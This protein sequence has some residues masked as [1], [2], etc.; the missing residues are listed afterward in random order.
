MK[1]HGKLRKTKSRL[2]K[3]SILSGALFFLSF[4]LIGQDTIQE[5]NRSHRV[6]D[7][8]L[9]TKKGKVL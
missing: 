2:Y 1:L 9:L 5:I 3:T 4:H 8:V 6:A 7:S